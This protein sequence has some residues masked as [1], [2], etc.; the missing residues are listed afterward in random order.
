MYEVLGFFVDVLFLF[1]LLYVVQ[2]HMTSFNLNK[3]KDDF[4]NLLFLGR[5]LKIL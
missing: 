2:T 4:P 1:V 3:Q 5:A